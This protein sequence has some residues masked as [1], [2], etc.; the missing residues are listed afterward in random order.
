VSTPCSLCG[1]PIPANANI[2]PNCGAAKPTPIPPDPS[3]VADQD[4]EVKNVGRFGA[5]MTATLLGLGCVVVLVGGT[6][7]VVMGCCGACLNWGS[8]SNAPPPTVD[9]GKYLWPLGI[10]I[11]LL[12][13]V[14]VIV[15]FVIRNRRR[16]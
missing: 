7:T 13:V 14:L 16:Q 2:C 4:Q 15:I 1:Y 6:L 11:V 5:W 12:W 3:F 10:G 9:L 8:N